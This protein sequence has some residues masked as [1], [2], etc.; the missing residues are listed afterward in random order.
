MKLQ[1]PVL[2][3][4]GASIALGA[5]LLNYAYQADPNKVRD[6]FSVVSFWGPLLFAVAITLLASDF[7][8]YRKMPRQRS[9]YTSILAL[10]LALSFAMAI[11]LVASGVAMVFFGEKAQSMISIG[12]ISMT[13]NSVGVVAMVGG[14]IITIH[15]V[16]CILATL[17][18]LDR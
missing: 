2:A 10:A 7:G 8:L 9:S 12:P 3:S 13:T 6:I 5:L 17:R 1:A 16:A 4:V 14:V 11:T 15:N 18:A